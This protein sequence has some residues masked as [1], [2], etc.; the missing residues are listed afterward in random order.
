ML[1]V[2]NLV[3]ILFDNFLCVFAVL[4]LDLQS[5]HV[6]DPGSTGFNSLLNAMPQCVADRREKATGHRIQHHQ[7]PHPH[8]A[9]RGENVAAA[10]MCFK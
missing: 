9:C 2:S 4:I 5:H 10:W 7:N 8:H 3:A 6:V 1:P